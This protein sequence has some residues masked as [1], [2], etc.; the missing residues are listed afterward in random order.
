MTSSQKPE[1]HIK[2]NEAD[3][4]QKKTVS[5]F[6][7]KA[8]LHSAETS[9]VSISEILS[10]AGIA[11]LPDAANERIALDDTV[12]I[13]DAAIALTQDPL[14]GFN[15]GRSFRPG[16]FHLIH[17]LWVN[18]P[19]VKAAISETLKYQSLISDGGQIQLIEHQDDIEVVYHIK[20]DALPFSFH[21]I[22]AVL[23]ILVSLMRWTVHEEFSPSQVQVT[24]SNDQWQNDYRQH[25]QCDIHF[26]ADHNSI[27]FSP[28]WLDRPII[29][30]DAEL[31]SMHQQLAEKSLNALQAQSWTQKVA[32]LQIQQDQFIGLSKEETAKLLNTSARTLQR[33]LKDE[34][35]SFF[36]ATDRARRS[37][38]EQLIQQH[39]RLHTTPLTTQLLAE[40]L[41]FL[42]ISS[43]HKAFKRWFDCKPGDFL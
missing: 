43:L 28:D 13:W 35:I 4:T 22:D 37:L 17:H 9:G 3:I 32:T 18:S 6:W 12:K 30:A 16:W 24:H 33:R 1:S 11:N 41:G 10:T 23:A 36:E 21:Q 19:N 7:L 27:H 25:H 31:L 8:I 14:F 40:K 2:H 42:E 26:D 15:M 39:K 5:A 20:Q 34:N 29:G 38:A